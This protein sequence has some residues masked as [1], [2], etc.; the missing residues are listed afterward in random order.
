M[1]L[2]IK[3][4]IMYWDQQLTRRFNST[5]HF[6]LITQLRNELK[7]QPLLRD[8]KTQKLIL[9]SLPAQSFSARD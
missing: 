6:R 8:L 1:S 7:S 2:S 3:I 5:V 9:Q 4:I